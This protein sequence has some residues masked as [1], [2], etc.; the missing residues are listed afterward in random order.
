MN[1]NYSNLNLIEKCKSEILEKLA[2]EKISNEYKLAIANLVNTFTTMQEISDYEIYLKSLKQNEVR[3]KFLV[4][5]QIVALK[6]MK[7]E[8]KSVKNL[9]MEEKGNQLKLIFKKG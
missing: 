9:I 4:E 2:N 1:Q 7:F 3:T 8:L 6:E 5:N